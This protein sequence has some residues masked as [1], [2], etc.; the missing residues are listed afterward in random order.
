MPH[1]VAWTCNWGPGSCWNS[2]QNLWKV[3]G[4]DAILYTHPRRSSAAG[5]G[6]MREWE[7]TSWRWELREEVPAQ[8]NS[9]GRYT[10]TGHPNGEFRLYRLPESFQTA[11]ADVGSPCHW[12]YACADLT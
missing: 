9:E 7:E 5:R 6:T 10:A 4:G 3:S 8:L 2:V 1:I 12:V 11:C